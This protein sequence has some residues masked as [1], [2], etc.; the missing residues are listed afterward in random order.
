VPR[1]AVW[2]PVPATWRSL[3]A[4]LLVWAV[5]RISAVGLQRPA[6]L[7]APTDRHLP[8]DTRA[9]QVLCNALLPVRGGEV[10]ETA[11]V[12]AAAS[13]WE[14]QMAVVAATGVRHGSALQAADS[15]PLRLQLVA[16][17]VACLLETFARQQSFSRECHGGGRLSNA[18]LLPCLLQLGLYYNQQCMVSELE[19]VRAPLLAAAPAA[20]DGRPPG[21]AAAGGAAYHLALALLVLSPQEWR[22][23]R[24]ALLEVVLQQAAA[25]QGP[26]AA[27]QTAQQQQAAASCLQLAGLSDAELHQQLGVALRLFGLVDWL[28]RE[29]KGPA[30]KAPA[31][32]WVRRLDGWLRDLGQVW[33]AGQQLVAQLQELEEACDLQECVD[34]M[35]LLGE[36]LGHKGGCSNVAE[37]VRAA[38]REGAAAAAGA[39]R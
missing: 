14:A 2:Q 10:S 11:Y 21:A 17:D 1:A 32:G 22:A 23:R 35:G 3:C 20:G 39:G 38:L 29:L 18:R 19:G 25:G 34:V 16:A 4:A 27:G 24:C 15:T 5:Q 31:E 26:T 12:A 13:F 28:Q 30:D 36:V 33:A 7:Q 9:L 6:L 8:P 37:F